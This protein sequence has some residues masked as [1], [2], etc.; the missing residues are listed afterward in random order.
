[1]DEE[2]REETFFKDR[3][4]GY[5]DWVAPL[6]TGLI[7]VGIVLLLFVIGTGISAI[8]DYYEVQA[9]NRIHETNYTFGEWFWAEGTIKDY[10]LGTVEN[11][12]VDLNIKK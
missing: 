9:F 4:G 6:V 3:Y 12:N 7:I 11:L 5:K 1:M 8:S 10:H 2:G